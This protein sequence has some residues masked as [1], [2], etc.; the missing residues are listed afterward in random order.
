ME[1]CDFSKWAAFD[2]RSGATLQYIG[3]EL[4]LNQVIL[5]R[6]ERERG[7]NSGTGRYY[8]TRWC[9]FRQLCVTLRCRNIELLIVKKK[10]QQQW[11]SVTT[12]VRRVLRQ[13]CR[14]SP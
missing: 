9:A 13:R 7:L 6:V 1:E 3:T 5:Q 12:I 10:N 4:E 2:A 8:D 11:I 14:K